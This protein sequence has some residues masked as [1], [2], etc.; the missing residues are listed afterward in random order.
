MKEE[1]FAFYNRSVTNWGC[2]CALLV[3][4]PMIK[5]DKI[6]VIVLSIC[7]CKWNCGLLSREDLHIGERVDI[8][9]IEP[10]LKF[11]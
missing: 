2:S 6:L 7:F 1:E 8:H 5:E 4:E 11:S 10:V 3:T 9:Y